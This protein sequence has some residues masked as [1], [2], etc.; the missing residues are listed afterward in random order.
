MTDQGNEAKIQK[1]ELSDLNN[2][3]KTNDFLCN[4]QLLDPVIWN[5]SK[6]PTQDYN[7]YYK[8]YEYLK[9]RNKVNQQTKKKQIQKI[10]NPAYE[11]SGDIEEETDEKTNI[12]KIS[13]IDIKTNNFSKESMQKNSKLIC[14]TE[15]D[16]TYHFHRPYFSESLRL[17]QSNNTPQQYKTIDNPYLLISQ[18]RN[19]FNQF[20]SLQFNN[21]ANFNKGS[22]SSTNYSNNKMQN[23]NDFEVDIDDNDFNEKYIEY[24]II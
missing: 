24:L 10:A 15:P 11:H 22:F 16:D 5:E 4:E 14:V 23:S 12:N 21:Q 20:Q 7:Q 18:Q 17:S 13:S 8:K 2:S 3:N 1:V 9:K 6:V 19:L